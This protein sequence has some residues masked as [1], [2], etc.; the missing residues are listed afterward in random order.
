MDATGEEEPKEVL[1]F[2]FMFEE[3][4]ALLFCIGN[5]SINKEGIIDDIR[6]KR[7]KH[8]ILNRIL[9]VGELEYNV[10]EKVQVFAYYPPQSVLK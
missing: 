3:I 8:W 10:Q 7:T 5:Q 1:F 6:E 4:T 9:K 2:P